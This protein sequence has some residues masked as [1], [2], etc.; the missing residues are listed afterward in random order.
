MQ[1]FISEMLKGRDNKKIDKA[2]VDSMI[3]ELDQRLSKQVNEILHHPTFQKLESAWRSLKYLVDNVNFRVSVGTVVP[4]RVR[5]VAV[6]A[7]IV[8]IRPQFRLIEA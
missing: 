7:E 8:E 3:A 4:A 2:A 6:P 5:V 1:A